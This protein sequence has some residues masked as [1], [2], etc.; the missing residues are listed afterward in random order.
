MALFGKKTESYLGVD[1]GAHGIKLVELRKTK[2]RPQLWTYGIVERELDIHISAKGEKQIG[3]LLEE[4]TGV[5]PLEPKEEDLDKSFFQD[6]RIDEYAELLKVL[7]KDAK[8][9]TNRATS[10]LPVSQVF[11]TIINFPKIEKKEIDE[12]VHAE[13]DK[14]LPR[15]VDD[16]QVVYQPVP[17]SEEEEKRYTRL[18]VTA[19]PKE[20]VAFY[21]SIFN[22]AGLQLYELETEAFALARSLVGIDKS[23]SILIDIGA[24]RTN[25]F[26]VDSGLPVTHRSI[27]IGGNNF[28]EL[29]ARNLAI[30]ID[31]VKQLKHDISRFGNGNVDIEPFLSL[32]DPIAKEIQYNFDIYLR[33]AGNQGKRPEKIILTG[34][35]SLFPPIKAYLKDLFPLKVFVGD[36]WARVIYQDGLKDILDE[37]GPRMAVSIGLALR[38][39]K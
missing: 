39:F 7:M 2:D 17:M 22:K 26:I 25:F 19:A 3:E 16:M 33:Q 12:I 32:L 15:S 37:I 34:G 4:K 11:H 9:Q 35:S 18:L 28:D 8:V 13:I 1:I 20:L 21:T 10:S 38:N 23:V 36:P 24:E 29:M 14:L 30:Q 5:S 6:K 27:Q 31:D